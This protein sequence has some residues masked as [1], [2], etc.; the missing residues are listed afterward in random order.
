MLQDST[1]Q[2]L[3]FRFSV[4]LLPV[5]LFALSQVPEIN[6]WHAFLIAIILHLLVYPSS[7]G[8]NSYMDRD[9]SPIG[10][11][12]KPMQPTE[13]L[14]TV[15]AIMDITAVLAAFFISLPFAI[16]LLLYITASRLYSNRRIRL[17]KYPLTG[18]LTVV[19]FQGAVTFFMVYHGCSISKTTAVPYLP[20]IAS[21]MLIGGF[22]PL[23]QIYQH[24]SDL[25]DGVKTLSY[26]LGYK[27]TFLYTGIIYTL[28]M[29]LMGLYFFQTGNNI[30]TVILAIAMLPVLVYFFR[31]ATMVWKDFSK[32]DFKHTM[33]MNE[34]ASACTNIGFVSILIGRLI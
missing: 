13:E 9:E 23:T 25:R 30:N 17:K 19:V 20:M 8:Y 28:A 32:A 27:G 18:Y 4:F 11:I 5:Y 12:E 2:L 14:K 22:Y 21:S 1:I 29:A 16:A 26:L 10:G 31:W 3:R 7:N 24:D 15:S 34:L 6:W 33:R